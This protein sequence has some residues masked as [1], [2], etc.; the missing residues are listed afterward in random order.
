VSAH[1][2]GGTASRSRSTR[3]R[4][5]HIVIIAGGVGGRRRRNSRSA[6]STTLWGRRYLCVCSTRTSGLSGG[7]LAHISC[8]WIGI[9]THGIIRTV[10]TVRN[11]RI[12][13]RMRRA[14]TY[15]HIASIA[16]ETIFVHITASAR[17]CIGHLRKSARPG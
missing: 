17:S 5:A 8:A 13:A 10:Y 7:D 3:V 16:V 2:R 6:L 9:G 11:M 15:G 12:I 1:A 4:G 14:S